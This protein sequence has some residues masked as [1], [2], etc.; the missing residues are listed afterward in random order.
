[1]MSGTDNQAF[2]YSYNRV[3]VKTKLCILLQLTNANVFKKNL[4][5]YM[6]IE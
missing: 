6:A 2:M 5:F 4:C 3:G 1:M